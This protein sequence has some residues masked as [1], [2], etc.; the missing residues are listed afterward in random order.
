MK[1]EN[2][3]KSETKRV[4]SIRG[5]GRVRP[6]AEAGLAYAKR[7]GISP[8]SIYL[9]LCSYIHYRSFVMKVLGRIP[10]IVVFF[11][12]ITVIIISENL[13]IVLGIVQVYFAKIN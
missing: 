6:Q 1:D 11:I 12:C 3:H 13:S 9:F 5:V 7:A 4:N 2:K 10:A 8:S